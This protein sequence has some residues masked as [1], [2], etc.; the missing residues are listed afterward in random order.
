M[1]TPEQCPDKCG[2]KGNL[3]K[4]TIEVAG[5]N[6]GT[7]NTSVIKVLHYKVI[8]SF[9]YISLKSD[10]VQCNVTA[11]QSDTLF[12]TNFSS[13]PFH[14]LCHISLMDTLPSCGTW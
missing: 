9:K 7:Q 8:Q 13:C 2:V 14:G 6:M 11:E 10:E 12:E 5:A 4:N 1:K 3:F